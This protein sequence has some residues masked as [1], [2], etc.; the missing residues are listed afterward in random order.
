MATYTITKTEP[1]SVTTTVVDLTIENIDTLP[2]HDILNGKITAWTGLP[3]VL[4]RGY[5]DL[6]A[7]LLL[8]DFETLERLDVMLT[9]DALTDDEATYIR[10]DRLIALDCLT[11]NLD[12]TFIFLIGNIMPEMLVAFMKRLTKGRNSL[13]ALIMETSGGAWLRRTILD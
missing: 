4:V 9:D 13:M 7:D 11:K 1:G 12:T 5:L 3:H 8:T 6:M 10:A 2:V